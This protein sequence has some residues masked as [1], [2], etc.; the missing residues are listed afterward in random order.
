MCNKDTRQEIIKA[1]AYGMKKEDIANFAEVSLEEIEDFALENQEEV[2]NYI[3]A[4]KGRW[5]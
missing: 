3:D 5:M 4:M 2:E 1:L